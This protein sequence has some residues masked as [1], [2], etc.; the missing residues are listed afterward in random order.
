M[1]IKILPVSLRNCVD[2]I[3]KLEGEDVAS[4]INLCFLC[5]DH[6]YRKLQVN[7]A[8]YMATDATDPSA[9]VPNGD[10]YTEARKSLFESCG[11]NV[12][13]IALKNARRLD[14]DSLTT[15]LRST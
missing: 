15:S 10:D 3:S 12:R 9:V 5:I 4:I 2:W 1:Q 8:L 13:A 7:S 14:F 6:E 11:R